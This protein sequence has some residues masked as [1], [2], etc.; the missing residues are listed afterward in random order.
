MD[1]KMKLVNHSEIDPMTKKKK[2]QVQTHTEAIYKLEPQIWTESRALK[3]NRG[4]LLN[5]TL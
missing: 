5:W 1:A 2:K 4:I 3:Q